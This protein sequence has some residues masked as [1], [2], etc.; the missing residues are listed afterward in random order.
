MPAILGLRNRK[1]AADGSR[2]WA[3][4]RLKKRNRMRY[5][6]RI[7]LRESE[8]RSAGDLC[9]GCFLLLADAVLER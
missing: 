5:I 1:G 9:S 4:R 3:R 8:S 2:R 7:V 6:S